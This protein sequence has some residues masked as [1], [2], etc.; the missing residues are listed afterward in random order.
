MKKGK[1][2]VIAVLL[3]SSLLLSSCIGSFAL[4]HKVLDW[5]KGISGNK[6]VNELVFIALNIV[7]VYGIASLA[8]MLVCNSIEFWS[9]SNPAAKVGEK[10]TVKGENGDFIVETLENGY[11]ISQEG[12]EAMNLIFDENTNSWNVEVNGEVSQ[13]LTINNDGTANLALPNGE[14]MNVTMDAQGVLAARQVANGAFY[15]AR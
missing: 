14:T 1:L 13:L 12:T 9:G 2:S 7:P 3:S 8:D 15:A 4:W 5:N 6:F 10:K 11:S